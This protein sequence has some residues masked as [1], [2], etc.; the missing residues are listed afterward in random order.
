MAVNTITTTKPN[1]LP[2]NL[3]L[4]IGDVNYILNTV[5]PMLK[6]GLLIFLVLYLITSIIVVKQIKMM[7]NTL[8]TPS[9]KYLIILGYIHL[10]LIVGVIAFSFLAL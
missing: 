4:A 2:V 8:A 10:G 7:V 9:E 1:D 6:W 3:D 5:Y